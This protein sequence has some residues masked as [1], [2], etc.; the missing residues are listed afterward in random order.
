MNMLKRAMIVVLALGLCGTAAWAYKEHR[1][2]EAVLLNAESTYQ[3]AFHDLAYKVDLLH[4]EIGNTLAMNSRKS[5]SPALA[6]VWRLTSEAHADVGQLPLSLLPFHKTEEFLTDIGNFSYRTAVRDLDKEPLSD[7][8]YASLKK[9]YGQS[10]DIQDQLRGVQ[11]NVLQH[12]LRWMDVERA[13]AQ[14][15]E[16]KDNTIIDGFKTVERTVKGYDNADLNSP[17]F[18]SFQNR[19]DHY[20]HLE[21]KMISKKQAVAT[22]KQYAGV[23]TARKAETKPN[24]K[25]AR[26]SFYTVRLKDKNGYETTADVTRKGG[27]PVW[28]FNKR[29]VGKQK[30][31]L[32]GAQKKAADFLNRH[33]FE[34]MDMFESMQYDNVGVFSFAAKQGNVRIYPETV[35]LKVAL[36]NG[37]VIGFVADDFL[38]SHQKRDIPKPAISEKEA[39]ARVNPKLDI[40]ESRLAIMTGDMNREVLCYEFLGVLHDETYR[41]YINA[42]NGNEE[43]V[44]KLKN[45]ERAYGKSI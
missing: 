43:K 6:E 42:E 22:V 21:G 40:M 45:T 37:Q 28:F 26:F 31:S 29:P 33:H 35:K 36:D 9:L 10:A 12:N 16:T 15:K 34:K 4:D 19:D 25:G 7:K 18:T 27:Y 44:E 2:K 24:Q 30:I 32:N 41:I 20:E 5:L 8:E 17:S 1:E 3:R 13:L 39:R 11:N 14:G 38:K 23:K